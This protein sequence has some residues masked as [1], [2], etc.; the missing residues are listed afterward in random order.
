M[1]PAGE[2]GDIGLFQGVLVDLV[3]EYHANIGK[4]RVILS[5]SSVSAPVTVVIPSTVLYY[6]RNVAASPYSGQSARAGMSHANK[7]C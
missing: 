7:R 4:A 5:W 6:I 2:F 1:V 3:L